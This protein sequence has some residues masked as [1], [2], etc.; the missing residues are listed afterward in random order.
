MSQAKKGGLGRGLAALIPTAPAATPG[1]SSAAASVIGLDPIGPQPASTYL[2]R[3]PDPTDDSAEL[4]AGGAIY[5]E[6]PPDQ[7]EPNPRQPRTV[8]EEE[9]L[10][11]LVHSIREFGLMQP[12][13]VRRVVPGADRYQLVMGERR[14]RA[15]QEAGLAIIPAIVRET[16][17]ESMLR[18]A[19]LE[20]IH[21]VQLNPLE[22]AAAYQQLL[23]EFDVT[24]EEL[25]ARLGRSRPVVTNMIRL[26][27]LPIPVQRRVA[28]GVLSA[29]H[30]RALL[31]LEAGADAQEVLAARIVAEGLSVRATEESVTL[32][33]RDPDATAPSPAPQ[34]KPIH[35]PGLQDVA[36]RLSGSFDTRVTVSLGKRKG[37]IVVEFGSVEDLERIVALMEQNT[38]TV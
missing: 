18:D 35:M 2:H 23:E 24:H 34:R 5:R 38:P 22:E 25:A 13:V 26:L 37:K 21:R 31:G 27:K 11:E 10:S 32:A 1:L 33:N 14:W 15:C 16:A 19:L 3:V 29:G 28:A 7:I 17:D 6:I 36:E 8:F 4:A 12:I 20:N 30:A 9:A